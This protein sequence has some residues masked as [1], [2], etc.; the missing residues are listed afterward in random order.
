MSYSSLP[1]K[2]HHSYSLTLFLVLWAFFGFL[3]WVALSLVS[4]LPIAMWSQGRF[5]LGGSGV[6]SVD[7]CVV[8]LRIN[9]CK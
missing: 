8:F 9:R 3:R 7:V 4:V 1:R 2:F 6:T 5:A